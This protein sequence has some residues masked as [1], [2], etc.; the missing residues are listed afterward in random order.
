MSAHEQDLISRVLSGDDR[1]AFRQLVLMHQASLRLFLRRITRDAATADDCAQETWFVV[2]RKL[3]GYRGGNFRAW[4][5]TIGMRRALKKRKLHLELPA[6]ASYIAEDEF[7][8]DW[9]LDLEK[10]FSQL[11][12]AERSVLHL[13]AYEQLTHEEIAAVLSLPLGTVKSHISRGREK[14]KSFLNPTG[15]NHAGKGQEKS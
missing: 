13:A 12:L 15:E 10:A 6:E 2:Y 1:H 9:R 5:L 11:N 14:L 8:C 7:R 3:S 4:L